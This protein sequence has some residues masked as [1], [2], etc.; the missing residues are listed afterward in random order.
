MNNDILL[1][2]IYNSDVS[3]IETLAKSCKAMY[4]VFVNNKHRIYKK[5]IIDE[6]GTKPLEKAFKHYLTHTSL[7]KLT[8]AHEC[9]RITKAI[10]FT[11]ARRIIATL[12]EFPTIQMFY[13]TLRCLANTP[14]T[15]PIINR[16]LNNTPSHP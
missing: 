11:R 1:E 6:F 13:K 16:I 2:I 3:T 9:N 5:L 12:P 8:R 10:R 14:R 4:S 7:T 15:P